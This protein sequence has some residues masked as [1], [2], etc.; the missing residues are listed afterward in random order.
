[1]I[2]LGVASPN[3]CVARSTSPQVEPPPTRTVRAWGIDV[4]RLQQAQVDDH[5]VVAGAQPGA[6]VAT[7]ADGQRQAAVAREADGLRDVLSRGAAR[8]HRRPLVDHRIVDAARL[9][10][11][12]VVGSDQAALEPGEL[13]P[14][15]LGDR[16]HRCHCVLLI[17]VCK[18]GRVATA[19]LP[20]HI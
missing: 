18:G 20:W 13:F 16:H 12:G 17:G 15:D 19:M 6:V 4:D 5:A 9:V 7:A 8:D 1:M 3:G 11:V 14:G 10:V 2:P